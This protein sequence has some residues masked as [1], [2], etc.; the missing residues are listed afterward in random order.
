M[1]WEKFL[2]NCPKNVFQEKLIK[3]VLLTSLE[4]RRDKK[5]YMCKKKH[6]KMAMAL[7]GFWLMKI[8]NLISV[9]VHWKASFS[10]NWIMVFCFLNDCMIV[11]QWRGKCHCRIWLQNRGRDWKEIDS[12]H[13]KRERTSSWE[14]GNTYWKRQVSI[15]VKFSSNLAIS[16]SWFVGGILLIIK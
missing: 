16:S 15:W 10:W 11:K 12:W 5:E 7:N 6:C 3:G 14:L 13:W 1:F 9:I 2:Q 8:S 4:K